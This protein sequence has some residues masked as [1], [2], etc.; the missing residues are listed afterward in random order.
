MALL[1]QLEVLDL[2]GNKLGPEAGALFAEALSHSRSLKELRLKGTRLRAA[3]TDALALMLATSQPHESAPLK[4]LDLSNNQIGFRSKAGLERVLSHL[5][6]PLQVNLAGNLVMTEALNVLT[7]GAGVIAATV[8][9]AWL[10]N[11]VRHGQWPLRVAVTV[12]ATALIACYGSS[13]LFHSAFMLPQG[14]RHIFHILDQCAIYLLIA[15]SYTPFMT[16]LFHGSKP[17]WSTFLLGF[18]WSLCGLG[19]GVE[20]LYHHAR[21]K[22][23]WIRHFSVALYVIMGWCAAFPPLFRDLRT[24]MEPRALRLLIAGGVAYTLGVPAFL[25][26]RNFDHVVWH[27]FVI[28]G[29]TLHYLS[30]K[31]TI[32]SK[33]V[34]TL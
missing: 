11:L 7:H 5:A 21:S 20:L 23:P 13:T 27:C 10:L 28:L 12:Y 33:L 6:Q 9:S 8:G 29:S 14:V 32:E 34:G 22:E 2:T 30:L 4:L 1:P 19:I 31:H 17:I 15:G 26:N 18:M 3:G 24:A 25:R 16:A